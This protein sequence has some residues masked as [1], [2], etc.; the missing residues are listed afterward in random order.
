MATTAA[1]VRAVGGHARHGRRVTRVL[2]FIMP[3]SGVGWWLRPV[4]DVHR[5]DM[6][7]ASSAAPF[8]VV[9]GTAACTV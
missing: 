7:S 6:R 8:A 2:S 9:R 4:A 3:S 5:D 1:A